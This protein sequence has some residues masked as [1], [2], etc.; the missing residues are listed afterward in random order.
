MTETGGFGF[1]ISEAAKEVGVVPATIRN[2]EKAGLIRAQ[3]RPNGYRVFYADD[4]ELMK[5]IKSKS[6]D[7]NMGLS[8]IRMLTTND[9]PLGPAGSLEAADQKEVRGVTLPGTKWKE[10]R[11]RRNYSLEDVSN[12]VGISASYLSKI[13]NEQ[14]NISYEILQKL[15]NFYGESVLTYFE[16][17]QNDTPVVRCEEEESIEIG[18]EGLEMQSLISR[19]KHTLTAHLCEVAPGCEHTMDSEHPGEEFVYVLS[20]KVEFTLNKSDSYMLSAGDS[21]NFSSTSPHRW[22]NISN[23]HA[24]LLWVCTPLERI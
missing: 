21:I 14:A 13:E 8:G 10:Y 23:R 22:R 3:R 7:E 9:S 1:N 20:G 5:R 6:I 18:L 19:R 4:I 2:W 17:G 11:L 24:R 12:L 15:A 16:N